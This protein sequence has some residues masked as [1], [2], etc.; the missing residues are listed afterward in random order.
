MKAAESTL[1]SV[2]L[3]AILDKGEF[4]QNPYPL[5]QRL[6]SNAPVCRSELW[7]CWVL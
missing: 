5:Y 3:D 1:S 2:E 4:A 7:G 6:R